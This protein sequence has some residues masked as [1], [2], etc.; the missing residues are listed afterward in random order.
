[1]NVKELIE[2]LQECDAEAEVIISTDEEG[3]G[4]HKFSDIDKGTIDPCE[5]ERHHIDSYCSDQ[6]SDA[7]CC[8]EPGER[9][10]FTKVICLW[11]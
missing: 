9:E 5:L 1:M 3:N 4:Y 10:T 8:L 6:H 11:P 7:D 2:L